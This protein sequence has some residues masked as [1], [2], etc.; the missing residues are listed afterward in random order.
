MVM[1]ILKLNLST[2]IKTLPSD[3]CIWNTW[4]PWS[5]YCTRFCGSD[6]GGSRQRMRTKKKE[7]TD[8]GICPG[9]PTEDQNCNN[10]DPCIGPYTCNFCTSAAGKKESRVF[11]FQKSVQNQ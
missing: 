5:P 8:A 1:W 10:T 4:E 3:D 9:Q 7:E 11:K 6:S 2:V